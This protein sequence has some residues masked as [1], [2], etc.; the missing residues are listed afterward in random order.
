MNLLHEIPSSCVIGLTL[1]HQ[2]CV[3]LTV[4]NTCGLKLR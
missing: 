3:N 1:K 2:V 4:Q